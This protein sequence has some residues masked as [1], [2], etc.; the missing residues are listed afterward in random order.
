MIE[1]LNHFE[2]NNN[3]IKIRELMNHFYSSTDDYINVYKNL[4]T[5]GNLDSKWLI[6]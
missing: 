1:R 2:F 6:F 4:E 3:D 5:E